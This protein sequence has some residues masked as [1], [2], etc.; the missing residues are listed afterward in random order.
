MSKEEKNLGRS[1]YKPRYLAVDEFS[2][3][4]TYAT[5][6]MDLELE[7]RW[8]GKGRAIK[9]FKKFEAFP[10]EYF[11]DVEAVGRYERIIQQISG[12]KYAACR[13][14]IRPDIICRHS[15]VKMFLEL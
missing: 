2:Q 4:Y 13:H 3:G 1:N 10:S 12:R 6:V 5:C 8:V 7:I 15:L 11:S 9:D 14:R